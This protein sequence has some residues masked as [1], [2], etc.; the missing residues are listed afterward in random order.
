MTNDSM[1]SM[2]LQPAARQLVLCGPWPHLEIL[3]AL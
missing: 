1:Y 2:G 3:H